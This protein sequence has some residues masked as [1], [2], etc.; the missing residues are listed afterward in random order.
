MSPRTVRQIGL[1]TLI[2]G[3]FVVGGWLAFRPRPVEC[4]IEPIER[5]AL[6]VR[7]EEDG[8]TRLTDRYIVSAPIAGRMDR[9]ALRP[10]DDVVAGET[11][12]ARIAPS[13]PDLLD[14]RARAEAEAR[15]RAATAALARAT[16]ELGRAEAQLEY[17]RTHYG[18]VL[19]AAGSGAGTTK[20]VDD[21]L[22]ELRTSEQSHAAARFSLE[23][24]RYELEQA[25]AA[26]LQTTGDDQPGAPSRAIFEVRS[27]ISGK[28]LR[29]MRESAGVV[30]PGNA[31]VE[32]G[33]LDALE[34]EVDVL[35]DQAVRVLPGAPVLLTG[36]GGDAPLSGVVRLVEPSGF[37]KVSALG[38]EEQRVNIIV[39]FVGPLSARPTL[40][41]NF[42][43]EVSIVVWESPDELVA[44]LGAL[45][46]DGDR[47]ATFVVDSGRARLRHVDIGERS[48]S[49]AQITGGLSEGERVIVFPSDKV[50]EGVRV[51]ER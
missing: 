3:A 48:S 14:E 19:D 36:W 47:W 39:D 41:D 44:P 5:R 31:L 22:L 37:T 6:T 1:W 50:D 10:G 8:R 23:I 9:I 20:E 25:R 49:H 38:V 30:S 33:S 13:D 21:A 35:S 42:R 24:A 11:V 32:L 7:V 40:G 46:R 12:L 2:I 4:D 17:A 51:R 29:V 34:I 26:L 18:R 15:V 16:A 43:V 27:P 28:T 45:F